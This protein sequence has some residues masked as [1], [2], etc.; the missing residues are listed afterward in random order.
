MMQ[1][2]PARVLI[3]LGAIAAMTCWP[4]LGYYESRE[5]DQTSRVY[6]LKH[7]PTL[8]VRFENIFA[9]GQAPRPLEQLSEEE[10]QVAIDYCLFRLGIES[11]LQTQQQLE[12]CTAR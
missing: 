6:F 3:T 11:P 2:T 5:G 1:L 10:R 12:L 4:L 9:N 7:K 8:Q